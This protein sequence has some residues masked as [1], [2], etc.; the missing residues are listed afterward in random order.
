MNC[1][2]SFRLVRLFDETSE[3]AARKRLS[4]AVFQMV[5]VDSVKAIFSYLWNNCG[6]NALKHTFVEAYDLHVGRE[7]TKLEGFQKVN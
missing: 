1:K 6:I 7:S 5:P 3:H 2:H 4:A